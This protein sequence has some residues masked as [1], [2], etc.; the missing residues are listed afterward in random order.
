MLRLPVPNSAQF[1]DENTLREGATTKYIQ[2][3]TGIPVPHLHH[4]GH[5][6]V[7]GPFSILDH[8]SNILSVSHLLKEPND[9]PSITHVLNAAIPPSILYEQYTLIA[10]FTVEL[11]QHTFPR[12]GSL[13]ETEDKVFEIAARP[14]TQNMNNMLDMG[15]I[16]RCILPSKTQT[17]ISADS[18]YI[19][20][21]E[22]HIAQLLFQHNDLVTSADDCRN[23]YV[24]RQLFLQLARDGRLS[25][26]GFAEDTWSAQ[27]KSATAVSDLSSAP[28]PTANFRLWCDDF[29]PGNILLQDNNTIAAIIDWEYTY[30]A[31]TQFALDPPWWLLLEVPEMWG[32]GIKDWAK[33]F[34]Q[35]LGNLAVSSKAHRKKTLYNPEQHKAFRASIIATDATE[36]GDRTVL[37]QLRCAEELGV[38]CHFLDFF[39]F[40]VLW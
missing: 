6:R 29:R 2:T 22:M 25:T 3:N 26:F 7:I 30:A 33:I 24:A 32:N 40:E 31:P 5:D 37:A 15:G 4:Y 36:L 19:A 20:L 11:S 39:G 13:V 8:I 1:P 16:P 34:E 18:W 9:D 12:I 17:Y 28:N 23:K 27:S 38:R 14:I 10:R 35:R 21:A